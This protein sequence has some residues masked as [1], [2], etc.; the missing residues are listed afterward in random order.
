LTPAARFGAG[1]SS[2]T[3]ARPAEALDGSGV[4]LDARVRLETL[5]VVHGGVAC[6]ASTHGPCTLAFAVP[7]EDLAFRVSYAGQDAKAFVEGVRD[8][9]ARLP[10]GWTTVPFIQ[11]GT[12]VEE[13]LDR[14]AGAGLRGESPDVDFPHYATGTVPS[15]GSVVAVGE[16]VEVTIGDG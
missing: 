8:S 12:S 4:P 6:R 10:N 14:L 11:L 16:T 9:A 15:A 5:T 7:G 1:V 3:V 13:A 2:L